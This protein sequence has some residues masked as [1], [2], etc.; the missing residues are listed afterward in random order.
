[1]SGVPEG[2]WQGLFL[3][4]HPVLARLWG[5]LVGPL[6]GVV[7]LMCSIR[8]LPLA[9]G[10][11]VMVVRLLRTDG[12]AMLRMWAGDLVA[13]AEARPKPRTRTGLSAKRSGFSALG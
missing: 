6:V 11:V 3:V 8:N 10:M 4:D 5:P 7:S 9:A 12:S 2:L 1:L 13:L